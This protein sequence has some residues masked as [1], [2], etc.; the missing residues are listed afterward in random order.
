[1]QKRFLGRLH[2]DENIPEGGVDCGEDRRDE[3]PEGE[4]IRVWTRVN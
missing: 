1:M 3:K 4:A 2:G